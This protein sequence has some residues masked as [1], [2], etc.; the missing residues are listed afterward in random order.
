MLARV[1]SLSLSQVGVLSKR[2]HRSSWFFVW[3]LLSTYP[4]Y[5]VLQRN[6]GI[7]KTVGLLSSK[8]VRNSGLFATIGRSSKY[9]I[10]YTVARQMWTPR[11]WWT[12][13]SSVNKVDKTS[14]LWRSTTVVYHSDG[15]ALSAARFRRAVLLATADT[16]L[17]RT[18]TNAQS[19][20][21][22]HYQR[23]MHTASYIS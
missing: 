16:C 19:R 3:W 12:L 4:S 15:Q 10:N 11:A 2:L 13:L 5:S 14:Q 18:P 8:S 9:V 20:N 22:P 6:S 1:L 21:I 7:Y 23:N 17:L